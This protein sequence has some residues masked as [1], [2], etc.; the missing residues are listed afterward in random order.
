[1]TVRCFRLAV[2]GVLLAGNFAANA[3]EVR[4]LSTIA[5]KDVMENLIPQF[6][7]ETG[8]KVAIHF[9]TTA[10]LKRQIDA[11]EDFDVAIF[12]PPELI[13]EMI[14]QGKI[15]AATRSDFAHTSVGVAVRT[16]TPRPDI[17]SAEAF[18]KSLLTAKSSAT[19][20]PPL[21]VPP[22]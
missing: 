5:V 1:M 8:H 22:G 15:V 12:T 19:P 17:S 21:V 16:G 13:E 7:R 9:G 20:I 3:G 10:V 6:E 2:A 18:K 14:K 11:G 4:V